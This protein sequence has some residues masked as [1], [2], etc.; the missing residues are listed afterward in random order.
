MEK[1]N[2]SIFRPEA[3]RRYAEGRRL[4]IEP[5]YGSPWAAAGLWLLLALLLA[6]AALLLLPLAPLLG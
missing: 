2:L 1:S 3:V 4:R 6:G 5:R